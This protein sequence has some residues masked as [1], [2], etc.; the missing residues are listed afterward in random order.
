MFYIRKYADCWAIHDDDTN[1]SRPLST[2]EVQSLTIE[3]PELAD[4][5]V[6]TVFADSITSVNSDL[7]PGSNST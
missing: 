7:P 4:E 6:R 5:F 3:F 2:D 1:A